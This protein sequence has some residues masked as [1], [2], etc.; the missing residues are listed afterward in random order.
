MWAF[1]FATG[2]S[3]GR[4]WGCVLG[5][6]PSALLVRVATRRPSALGCGRWWRDCGSKL[7][8][9][10]CQVPR[11]APVSVSSIAKG[12]QVGTAGRRQGTPGL[13]VRTAAGGLVLKSQGASRDARR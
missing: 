4:E 8:T 1:G 5:R 10:W 6:A 12:P 3:T 13:L 11:V 7:G 9:K 2:S